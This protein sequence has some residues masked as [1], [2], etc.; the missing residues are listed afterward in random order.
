MV[1]IKPK[2][3]NKSLLDTLLR[4]QDEDV[5]FKKVIT[6]YWNNL[7]ELNEKMRYSNEPQVVKESFQFM[8]RVYK[9]NQYERRDGSIVNKIL[10]EDGSIESRQAL[11]LSMN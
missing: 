11:P 3:H 1:K 2:R 8:K 7:N 10:K 9:Y 5:D 6:E 4:L